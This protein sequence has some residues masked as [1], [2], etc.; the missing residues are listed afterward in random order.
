MAVKRSGLGRGLDALI[1]DTNKKE[2]SPATAAEKGPASGK[3]SQEEKKVKKPAEKKET[4]AKAAGKKK[5]STSAQTAGK[6]ESKASGKAKTVKASTTKKVPSKDKDTSAIGTTLL[7]AASGER[8]VPLSLVEPNRDQPRKS[9]DDQAIAELAD[10]IRQYGVISP[11]LVQVKGDHYEI[12]AGERRWRACHEAKVTEVPVVIRDYSH[13]EAVEI[14][15]IENIQRQDLNPIEEARAYRN[16]M[17]DFSLNQEQV[18]AKVSKSRAAVANSMRLL[19]LDERVQNLLID[20]SLT[21]GHARALLAVED[22]DR[23]AALAEEIVKNHATVRQVEQMIKKMQKPAKK[24]KESVRDEQ[25]EAVLLDITGKLKKALGT[26]VA[27]RE[28]ESGRG[29]I[30][31]DYYS[32]DELETIYECLLKAEEIKG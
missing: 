19:K 4:P 14:A 26:K 1:R 11:I 24:A 12:I 16:L 20:R 31:I 17:E 10:S 5:P 22:G 28:N 32:D 3:T 30:E 9:F 6:A 15:L 23:Q 29:R 13:Q 27:I 25:R 7:P 2:K 18:A 8:V 21:E